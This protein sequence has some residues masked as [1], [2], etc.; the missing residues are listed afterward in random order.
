MREVVTILG[1]IAA[2]IIALTLL[3]RGNFNLGT[4]KAGPF[5]SFGYTGFGGG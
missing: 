2:L 5:A 3:G 1:G 4:G